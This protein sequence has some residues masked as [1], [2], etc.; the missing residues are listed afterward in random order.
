MPL[1]SVKF[2]VTAAPITFRRIHAENQDQAIQH[3]R[4]WALHILEQTEH[5]IALGEVLAAEE[6]GP[7][8]A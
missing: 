5:A 3:T 1:Y 6:L 2:A 7:D 4:E 8:E